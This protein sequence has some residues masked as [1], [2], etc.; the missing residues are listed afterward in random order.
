MRS[1]EIEGMKEPKQSKSKQCNMACICLSSC[2]A[3]EKIR[4]LQLQGN[5]ITNVQS[6]ILVFHSICLI[7][8][9]DYASIRTGVKRETCYIILNT[10]K[11]VVWAA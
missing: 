11:T 4:T 8:T 3:P 1:L 7:I 10:T 9:L 6:R 5:F 2:K